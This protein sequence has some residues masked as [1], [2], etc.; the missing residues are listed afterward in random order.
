MKVKDDCVSNEICSND[1]YPEK[2]LF[3]IEDKF[4]A[5]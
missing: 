4:D 2:E 3:P 1:E 5:L